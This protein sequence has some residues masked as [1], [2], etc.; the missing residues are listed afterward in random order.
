MPDQLD[1]VR[2]QPLDPGAARAAAAWHA[3]VQLRQA[4]E[5]LGLGLALGLGLGL[6]LVL[7][8]RLGL[9]LGLGLVLVLGLGLG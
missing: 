5:D 7:E 4:A 6:G 9:G 2:D 8:L 3:R 1:Q